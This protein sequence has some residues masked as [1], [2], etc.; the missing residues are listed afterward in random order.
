M[1]WVVTLEA[2]SGRNMFKKD[3]NARNMTS[4]KRGVVLC[5][6]FLLKGVGWGAAIGFALFVLVYFNHLT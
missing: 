2:T 6:S 5:V 3:L 1:H 4:K